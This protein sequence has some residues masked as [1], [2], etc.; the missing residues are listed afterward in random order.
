ME[1]LYIIG[2][3]KN[4]ETIKSRYNFLLTIID[5][6]K[7][8]Q[9]NPQYSTYIQMALDRYKTM[10][11]DRPP[12][13]YQLAILSNPNSFDLNNFYCNSLVSTMKRF[14]GEQAKEINKMKRETAKVKRSAK[15]LET[16]RISKNELQT[17]CSTTSSYSTALA[18]LE[19]L[20]STLNKTL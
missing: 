16:I 12:K 11:N 1:T 3:S 14:C 9:N 8:G 15:V 4:I 10:Y 6:L 19:K 7:H 13:D 2:T 20:E 18:E 5:T 17:K